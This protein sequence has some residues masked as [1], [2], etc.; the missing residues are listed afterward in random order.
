MQTK[1]I[2]FNDS[3]LTYTVRGTGIPVMFIH[4]FGETGAIWDGIAAG[5]ESTCMLIIP[6]LPGSGDSAPL[7][8]GASNLEQ[9]AKALVAII[10]A[11][12]L[13][14]CTLIGHSMGGYIALALAQ[15]EPHLVSGMGLF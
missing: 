2:Q 1:T 9:Y 3:L 5:L 10:E 13:P 14:N 15:S 11:E 6:D 12:N 8:A 4:G 7:H